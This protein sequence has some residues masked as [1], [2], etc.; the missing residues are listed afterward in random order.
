MPLP[1]EFK[2]R[3]ASRYEEE[4][5]EEVEEEEGEAEGSALASDDDA[6]ARKGRRG[7]ERMSDAVMPA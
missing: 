7:E 3:V 1:R 4:V 2:P 6:M 5:E